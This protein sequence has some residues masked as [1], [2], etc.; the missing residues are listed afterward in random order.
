MKGVLSFLSYTCFWSR[1][2]FRLKISASKK[3][4]VFIIFDSP[5]YI[6]L[7]Y[8][9]TSKGTFI[10]FCLL[11]ETV[12]EGVAADACK[13]IQGASDGSWV[14]VEDRL[15]VSYLDENDKLPHLSTPG[16]SM[17]FAFLPPVFIFPPNFP[18]LSLSGVCFK[19]MGQILW[20]GCAWYFLVNVL[21]LDSQKT[22]AV[23]ITM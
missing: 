8:S 23:F 20:N 21:T 12:A 10:R 16:K 6:Y 15:W 18:P 9:F 1:W 19:N 17:A 11:V 5:T 14:A 7:D 3:P 2:T 22:F 4:R 13:H